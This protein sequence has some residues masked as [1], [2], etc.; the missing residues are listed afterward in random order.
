MWD[1]LSPLLAGEGSGSQTTLQKSGAYPRRSSCLR[2]ARPVARRRGIRS[3]GWDPLCGSGDNDRLAF[4]APEPVAL[5]TVIPFDVVRGRF[6]LHQLALRDDRRI[7]GP[8][9][10]AKQLHIPLGKALDHLLQGRLV[11]PTTFPVQEL[12][13]IRI[14]GLPDPQLPSLV[15]EVVPHLVQLQDDRFA[16]GLRLLVVLLRKG[17]EPVEHGLGRYPQEERDTM[18]GEATQI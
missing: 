9:I 7:C 17:S 15:L 14:Q 18:H 6:T 12:A 8:L 2:G 4:E 16:S 1:A 10:G 11:T 13:G 5:P 3:E